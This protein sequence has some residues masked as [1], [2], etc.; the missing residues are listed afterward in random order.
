MIIDF[1]THIYPDHLAARTLEVLTASAKGVIPHTD[2]TVSGL[3]SGMEKSGID[4]SVILPVATRKGQFDTINRF[5]KGINESYDNLI[6]FGGIHPDDDDIEGKL[7]FLSENGFKGIKIHPDYTDTFI[8]DERY[9]R[10]ITLCQ[11]LGLTVVTHGGKDVAYPVVHCT[12][13]RGR[14]MLERVYENTGFDEPFVVFA[15]LCGADRIDEVERYLVGQ[16]C[17]LDI[18]CSF[19]GIGKFSQLC[20]EEIV[21]IIKLHG[22]DK[23]LFASDS[24]W[25]DQLAYQERMRSLGGISDGEKEMIFHQNAERLLGL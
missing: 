15:H 4:K 13:Q 6:S 20:D 21:R 2:A 23:I 14:R 19:K 25:N 5:A 7:G 8:D 10:I 11:R 12:P 3:L 9:V 18:S 22:A 17:Y 1:H 16:N 24:P